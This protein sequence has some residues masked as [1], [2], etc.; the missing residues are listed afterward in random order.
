MLAPKPCIVDTN[1]AMVANG[2]STQASGDMQIE[3]I[4]LLLDITRTGGLVLDAGDRIFEEYR[5]NLDLAGQPGAGDYFLKW[6]H[7]NRWNETR[8]EL[9]HIECMDEDTQDFHEFPSHPGLA[10]F[11]ISDRKFVATANA[12]EVKPPIVQAVDFK[13]WGWKGALDEAGIPVFFIDEAEAEAGYRSL[14]PN[15][16]P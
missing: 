1:V 11:D 5:K 10:N 15:A 9:R 3:C 6:V 14:Y 7:D 8:C 16:P 12:G 4:D 2:G 13:W